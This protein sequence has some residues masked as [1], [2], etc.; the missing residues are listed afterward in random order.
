MICV[1]KYSDSVTQSSNR[2]AASQIQSQ[3]S[4]NE[5][6]DE[7]EDTQFDNNTGL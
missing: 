7:D 4:I 6:S 1:E 5:F 3:L 2:T